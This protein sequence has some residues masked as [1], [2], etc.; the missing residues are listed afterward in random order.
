MQNSSKLSTRKTP[1]KTPREPDA[2]LAAQIKSVRSG[3]GLLQ[4][5]LAERLKVSKSQVSEWERGGPEAPSTIKLL[6]LATL[7]R[8]PA[9][10]L[11]FWQRAGVNLETIKADIKE[12]FQT[13]GNS[14]TSDEIRRV[15]IING[16]ELDH[17]GRLLSSE[18]GSIALPSAR[19]SNPESV[20]CL[21]FDKRPPWIMT[22]KK[23]AIVDRSVAGPRSL[24]GKEI[25][26]YFV[27]Y[28]ITKD[29]VLWDSPFRLS[30]GKEMFPGGVL[31]PFESQRINEVMRVMYP[32]Y[33]GDAEPELERRWVRR[34]E[35][36]TRPGILAG[37]LKA[38]E[39]TGM[40]GR[41]VES[42]YSPWCLVLHIRGPLSLLDQR[43][44]L[45]PWQIDNKVDSFERDSIDLSLNPGVL[46]I[47]EIVGWI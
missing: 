44:A 34:M 14:A 15:P 19:L 35:E 2:V 33:L 47:G 45:S 12:E 32:N 30:A 28:P 3:L 1:R 6:D 40:G 26:V 21:Q 4:S 39:I 25:A 36:A 27:D 18:A 31:E 42:T 17:H 9:A 41:L 22:D 23:L 7:A 46:I 5:E 43:I 24:N 38:E 11:W 16:F 29:S 37:C 8:T 10:R 20:V 13:R